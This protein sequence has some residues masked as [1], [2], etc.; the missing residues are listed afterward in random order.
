VNPTEWSECAQ[1][2]LAL[3]FSLSAA[4]KAPRAAAFGRAVSRLLGFPQG[5]S[6]VAAWTVI[7]SEALLGV[8]LAT[9]VMLPLAV[10]AG[11]A[12]IALFIPTAIANAVRADP[13]PCFCFGSSAAEPRKQLV[14]LGLILALFAFFG[15]ALQS[16]GHGAFF[17]FPHLANAL[18]GLGV[19][20]LGIWV[21]QAAELFKFSRTAMPLQ[22][23]SIRRVSLR[24]LDLAPVAA[25]RGL[26]Q[27][28][29][30]HV[31]GPVHS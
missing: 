29:N 23:T 6:Q 13:V 4:A 27:G 10:P 14:R 26:N 9:G 16:D 18:I 5:V 19:V 17:R 30:R 24:D 8:S 25:L 31:R 3:V 21:L 28:G 7:V 22:R 12:L 11:Y 15:P 2:A 1:A 20:L